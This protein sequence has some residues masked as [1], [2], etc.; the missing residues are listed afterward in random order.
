MLDRPRVAKLADFFG[1]EEAASWVEANRAA[2]AQGIFQGFVAQEDGG[3]PP[4]A[5]SGR[6]E[7]E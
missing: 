6:E 5:G 2:F 7:E 1:F 3:L 4:E